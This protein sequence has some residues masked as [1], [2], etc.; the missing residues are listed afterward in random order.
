MDSGTG[1]VK[2]CGSSVVGLDSEGAAGSAPSA[3]GAGFLLFNYLGLGISDSPSSGEAPGC[4]FLIL[5]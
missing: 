3:D 2:G 5:S 4:D 1:G